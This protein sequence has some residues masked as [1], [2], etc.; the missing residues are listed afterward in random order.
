MDAQID[1]LRIATWNDS[2]QQETTGAL[3]AQHDGKWEHKSWLQY[4][5]WGAGELFVG[6]GR[7]NNKRHGLIQVSGHSAETFY[8]NWG[9]DL[10]DSYYGTRIDIQV[11][12]PMPK[13]LSL[14]KVHKSLGKKVSTLISS[15]KNDTVY[16]GSRT[17]DLFTR[18]Y[19]KVL[20]KKYLRLEFELKGRRASA[21]WVALMHGESASSIFRY[22]LH[23]TKL[24]VAVTSY[25]DLAEHGT[26]KR[27][28]RAELIK[29]AEKKLKWL[30]SLDTAIIAMMNDHDIGERTRDLVKDWATMAYKID[31]RHEKE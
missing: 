1:Y 23:K 8:N 30:Q 4:T 21:A 10:P 25:Y 28:M 27:A 20:D 15:E 12:I 5:G 31:N 18:L 9:E 3:L 29:T 19:E 26:T 13:G 22:Y 16:V 7:Q 24:P 14:T 6:R 11:T 2:D 17:S